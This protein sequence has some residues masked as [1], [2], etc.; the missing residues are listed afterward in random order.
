[1]SEREEIIAE[2]Q[3]AIKID[4]ENGNLDLEKILK[5]KG[6]N[7]EIKQNKKIPP[8]EKEEKFAKLQAIR[9]IRDKNGDLNFDAVRKLARLAKKR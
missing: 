1:M 4:D 5:L 3:D 2:L 7:E 6:V 9:N 8:S